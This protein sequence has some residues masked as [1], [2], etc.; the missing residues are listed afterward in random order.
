MVLQ[1][2]GKVQKLGWSSTLEADLGSRSISR[3]VVIGQG[4]EGMSLVF[5]FQ[6]SGGVN[7][8]EVRWNW[9]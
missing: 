7:A 6:R 8:T 9:L 5:T 2:L 3:K 4:R 1:N